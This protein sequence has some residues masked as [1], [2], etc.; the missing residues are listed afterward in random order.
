MGIYSH[1]YNEW[2]FLYENGYSSRKIAAQYGCDKKTVLEGIRIVGGRV[3]RYRESNRKFCF[4][5]EYFKNIATPEKAYWLGFIQADGSIVMSGRSK[6]LDIGLKATDKAH[7][8]KFLEDINLNKPVR[9]RLKG[10]FISAYVRI[11]SHTFVDYLIQCGVLPRKSYTETFPRI[12][13]SE[14][15]S[16]Y[17]RGLFDGDGHVGLYSPSAVF[18]IL[19][20][21]ALCEWVLESVRKATGITGGTVRKRA[22][23]TYEARIHGYYLVPVYYWLYDKA[24]RYL[25]R[26]RAAFLEVV[27]HYTGGPGIRNVE[28]FTWS[29]E[30]LKRGVVT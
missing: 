16:H 27:E 14:L 30:Y 22:N 23:T 7:L 3:R 24:T 25:P 8:E 19:G 12:D 17:V 13:C 2:R 21:K 29:G 9:T 11:S 10:K 5:E 15:T 20:S 4:D 28:T 6:V 26:K 18:Y 1:L